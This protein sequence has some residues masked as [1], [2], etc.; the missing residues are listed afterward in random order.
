MLWNLNFDVVI[1]VFMKI[2]FC[3][4][5]FVWAGISNAGSLAKDLFDGT[6][7]RFTA[8]KQYVYTRDWKILE[9]N[10]LPNGKYLFDVNLMRDRVSN[11]AVDVRT[12]GKYTLTRVDQIDQAVIS[13]GF[14]H[15]FKIEEL[16]GNLLISPE[17]NIFVS[18]Y[19]DPR[20]DRIFETHYVQSAA[21]ICTALQ[22]VKSQIQ[23]KMALSVFKEILLIAIKSYAGASYSGG[24]FSGTTA[25]GNSVSGTY[26]RYD[27]SW[28]GPHYERGLEAVF[29]GSA[30]LGQVE[31]QIS[32]LGCSNSN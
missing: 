2:F 22:E 5:I 25:Y 23:K 30:N 4:F 26:S 7:Q 8:F 21:L 9:S 32:R 18:F 11:P 10:E 1:I 15:Q 19:Y 20:V 13:Q 17:R 29:D 31:D 28:L 12:R 27:N 6:D 14:S 16:A 3:F 24:T